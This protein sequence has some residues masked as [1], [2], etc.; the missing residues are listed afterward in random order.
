MTNQSDEV[1]TS[2]LW[3]SVLQGLVLPVQIKST[4]SDENESQIELITDTGEKQEKCLGHIN[5]RYFKFI[6][7][8]LQQAAYSQIPE[9]EKHRIHLK[10]GKQL[11]EK[12]AAG[13]WDKDVFEITN[14]FNKALK[15]V[16][17]PQERYDLAKMNLF[18]GQKALSATAYEAA[19]NYLAIGKELLDLDCWKVEYDLSLGLHET[20]AEAAFLTGDFTTSEESVEEVLAQAKTLLE[21][22]KVYEIRIQVNGAQGKAVE[23]VDTALNVLEQ[24]GIE[25]PNNPTQS[26]V[27]KA[28][29]ETASNL[30]GKEIMELANLPEMTEAE[31]LAAMRILSSVIVFSYQ[32][33]PQLFVL[34]VLKKV[35]LSA[36]YGNTSLSAFSYVAYGVI[37]CGILGDINSGYQFG[38]LGLQI[39]GKFNAE[40]VKAKTE[41]TFYALISHWKKPIKK[42]LTPLKRTSNTGI[43][44]GDLEFIAYSI[45]ASC[46]ASY[47]IGKELSELQKEIA[48]SSN[49]IS[50]IKQEAVVYW[51]EIYRQTV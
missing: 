8:R 44:T 33:V 25:F 29:A 21:K 16:V 48:I 28:M 43:E 50:Q 15:L 26:D 39:I 32:A 27:E 17:I 42:L 18:A 36:T 14:Q 24:L 5:S 4:L 1:T 38:L 3:D 46:Y 30:A 6:H 22:I 10:L 34:M 40:Q 19:F 47:F 2:F 35:Y 13:T 37:L 7:D 23:A 49:Y 20:L 41:Q 12:T 11:L 31:P 45:N 51:N 9:A